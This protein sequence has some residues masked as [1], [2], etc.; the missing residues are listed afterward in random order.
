MRERPSPV[1]TAIV[2]ARSMGKP[3]GG[4]HLDHDVTQVE[5]AATAT[6]RRLGA[7]QVA[8]TVGSTVSRGR[9]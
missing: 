8:V 3:A 1:V 7:R 5:D 2:R 6:G 4:A 9:R